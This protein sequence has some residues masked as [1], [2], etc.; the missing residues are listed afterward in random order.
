MDTSRAQEEKMER[1]ILM[2]NWTDREILLY[3]KTAMENH[4]SHHEM[5]EKMIV[6]ALLAIVVAMVVSAVRRK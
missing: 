3:L 1:Q 6:A 5:Y 2:T 4:L